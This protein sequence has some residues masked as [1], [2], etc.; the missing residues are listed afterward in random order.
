MWLPCGVPSWHTSRLTDCG[1]YTRL[2]ACRSAT[3]IPV[4]L[5]ETPNTNARY[6]AE[7]DMRLLGKVDLALPSGWA[8]NVV[9]ASDYNL[10]V[11]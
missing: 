3:S 2:L 6:T 7:P 8:R 11:C 5:Y 1:G 4:E 10:L 9:K